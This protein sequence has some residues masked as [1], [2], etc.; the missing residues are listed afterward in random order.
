MW[1]KS[2]NVNYPEDKSVETV[3]KVLLVWMNEKHLT[4]DSISETMIC[5]KVW[6]L[7]HDLLQKN[8]P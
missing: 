8:P 1:K 4:G 3:Q 2:N 6:I 5:G 7:H